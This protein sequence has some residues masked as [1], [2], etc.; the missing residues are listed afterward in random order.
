MRELSLLWIGPFGV[1]ASLM[2]PL[3]RPRRGGALQFSFLGLL[4]DFVLCGCGMV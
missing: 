4:E 3:G 1:V 2:A